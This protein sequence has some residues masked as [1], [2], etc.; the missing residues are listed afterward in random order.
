MK[1]FLYV[2]AEDVS[3]GKDVSCEYEGDR[4]DL[5]IMLAYAVR[6]VAEDTNV[7]FLN[8]LRIINLVHNE[9]LKT[10]ESEDK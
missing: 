5:A 2:K 7:S 6:Q 9:L 1:R 10:E 4:G 3:G 8:L